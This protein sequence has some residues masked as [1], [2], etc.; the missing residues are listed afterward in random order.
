MYQ[1]HMHSRELRS[2]LH[3]GDDRPLYVAA[4][5][6]IDGNVVQAFVPAVFPTFRKRVYYTPPTG[7]DTPIKSQA[8]PFTDADETISIEQFADRFG[9]RLTITTRA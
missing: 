1:T 7:T 6:R 2:A 9:G 5:S 4:C 8:A 3:N